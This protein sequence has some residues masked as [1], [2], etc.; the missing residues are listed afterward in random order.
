MKKLTAIVLALIIALSVAVTAFAA[1]SLE[2]PY[3]G[4]VLSSEK[5]Y[6]EHLSKKCPVVGSEAHKK[7]DAFF[8]ECPYGCG[9]TFT[10]ESAYNDHLE[11]CFSKKDPTFAEQVEDFFLNFNFDET[12]GKVEELLSKVD[13]PSILV[14]I[15]DLLEKGVTAIIGAI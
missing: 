11:V 14:T 3:C 9:A 5:S 13:F 1:V 4:E 2:C 15:I 12:L 6:N 10:K 7:D 8:K